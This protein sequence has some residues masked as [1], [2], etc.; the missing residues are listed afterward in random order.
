LWNWCGRVRNTAKVS[1][2]KE[3]VLINLLQEIRVRCEGKAVL[4]LHFLLFL[5]YLRN[6][7]LYSV[8]SFIDPAIFIAHV[9][10]SLRGIRSYVLGRCTSTHEMDA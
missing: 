8:G 5:D 1:I 2:I 9:A 3:H 10:D 7:F 6:K 4:Y